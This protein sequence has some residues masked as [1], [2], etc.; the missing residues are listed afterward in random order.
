MVKPRKISCFLLP[1]ENKNID[2]SSSILI[3]SSSPCTNNENPPVR[4]MPS[5]HPGLEIYWPLTRVAPRL[6]PSQIPRKPAATTTTKSWRI[7]EEKLDI[8]GPE[9]GSAAKR[10]SPEEVPAGIKASVHTEKCRL[11]ISVTPVP[12]DGRELTLWVTTGRR[13]MPTG[14]GYDHTSV[15]Q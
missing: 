12:L 1:S 9:R 10:I 7:S 5:P 8:N 11:I 6:F 13:N 2:I 15:P 3:Y 14:P 4:V